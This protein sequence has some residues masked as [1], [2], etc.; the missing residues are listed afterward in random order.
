MSQFVYFLSTEPFIFRK[1]FCKSKHR[2]LC[3]QKI[4]KLRQTKLP[5]FVYLSLVLREL[6]E[7]KTNIP[8]LG[9]FYHERIETFQI[10]QLWALGIFV[11]VS[12]M[13]ENLRGLR[14]KIKT[15][16]PNLKRPSRSQKLSN[17]QIFNSFVIKLTKTTI[18]PNYQ[19]HNGY[20]CINLHI[21][22]L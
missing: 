9:Q 5:Q 21:I 4:Y 3:A 19:V 7:T 13:R 22:Y 2:W 16:N 8:H 20:L 6:E 11:S 14:K 1:L 17:L 12:L 18:L 10:A 15:Q